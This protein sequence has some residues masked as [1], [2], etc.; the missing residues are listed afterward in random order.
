V[1]D[2]PHNPVLDA[3]QRNLMAALAERKAALRAAPTLEECQ[4][5]VG[6]WARVGT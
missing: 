1:L 3:V 4:A 5:A 6:A 2:P